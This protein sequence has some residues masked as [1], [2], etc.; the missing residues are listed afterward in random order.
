V[1]HEE[2][3]ETH[4]SLWNWLERT[5][6]VG[7]GGLDRMFVRDVWFE[8]H[9]T[10][11]VELVQPSVLTMDFLHD[12]QRW[13]AECY[14]TWRIIVPLFLGEEKVITIY[15]DVLRGAPEYEADWVT[16]LERAR[17]QMANLPQFAHARGQTDGRMG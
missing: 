17:E 13:I 7:S 5:W 4:E 15:R 3:L 1:S 12:L 10:H 2:W 8:E 14:P 16:A 9:R 6:S 11:V